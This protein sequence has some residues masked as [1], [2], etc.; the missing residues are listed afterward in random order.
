[1]DYVWEISYYAVLGMFG[2][3]FIGYF[4]DMSMNHF[5]SMAYFIQIVGLLPLIQVY[6]PS[7]ASL[8]I[9]GKLS[10]IIR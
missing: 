6:M 5:W 4:I 3:N 2:V 8:Y 1:M 10:S 9:L 7:C